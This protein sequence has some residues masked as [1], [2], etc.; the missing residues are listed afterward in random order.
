MDL[1]KQATISPPTI[2]DKIPKGLSLFD[3]V[4]QWTDAE[5]VDAYE[6]EVDGKRLSA[7]EIQGIVQSEDYKNRLLAF[8]ER[9]A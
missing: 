3:A 5:G 8:H 4:K 1:E 6:I 7:D 9:L 2:S